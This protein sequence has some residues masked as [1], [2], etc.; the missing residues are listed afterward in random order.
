MCF[1]VSDRLQETVM[2]ILAQ[3]GDEA[4]PKSEASEIPDEID[5]EESDEPTPEELNET[6]SEAE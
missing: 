3:W 5:T 4:Q 1:D 2:P 6:I